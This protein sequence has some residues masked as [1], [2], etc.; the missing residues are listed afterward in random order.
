M[1]RME[2]TVRTVRQ[3]AETT[4]SRAVFIIMKAALT[5]GM[6][7]ERAAREADFPADRIVRIIGETIRTARAARTIPESV[8]RA[9]LITVIIVPDFLERTVSRTVLEEKMKEGAI[10]EES[11]EINLKAPIWSL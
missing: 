5:I 7:E 1:D 6:P 10:P 8:S 2:K 3:T 4:V 9:A 11:R